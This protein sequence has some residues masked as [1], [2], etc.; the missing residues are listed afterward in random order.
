[1]SSPLNYVE[2]VLLNEGS[3][4]EGELRAAREAAV[5]GQARYELAVREHNSTGLLV[6]QKI[7]SILS[8]RNMNPENFTIV[9]TAEGEL[10]IVAKDCGRGEPPGSLRVEMKQ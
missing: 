3:V 8:N 7:D 5:V 4:L 10:A 2:N 6:N 1:M 9:R